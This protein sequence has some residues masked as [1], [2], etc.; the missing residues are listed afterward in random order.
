MHYGLAIGID[1]AIS[2]IEKEFVD[3]GLVLHSEL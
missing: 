3:Y 2:V 1:L